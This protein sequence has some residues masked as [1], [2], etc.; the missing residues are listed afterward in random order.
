MLQRYIPGK[1][2]VSIGVQDKNPVSIGATGAVGP[3]GPPGP[4]TTIGATGAE[5][6]R[7]FMGIRGEKGLKGEAG[8]KGSTGAQGPSGPEGKTGP[9]GRQGPM[10]ATGVMGPHGYMGLRGEMGPSGPIGLRGDT[11]PMGPSG[12]RGPPGP[13]TTIGAT[14]A[15]GPITPA[16]V[17]FTDNDTTLSRTTITTDM[18]RTGQAAFIVSPS[19]GDT[20][21]AYIQASMS[22]KLSAITTTA[23]FKFMYCVGTSPIQ[24]LRTI[25]TCGS[26]QLIISGM[27]P[28]ISV[29]DAVYILF[30]TKVDDGTCEILEFTPVSGAIYHVS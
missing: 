29:G 13:A 2:M 1:G 24:H 30:N 5:G 21:N 20:T 14:G 16:G 22:V 8:P 3:Q 11:G 25:Y 15:Q 9:E 7:G 27:I 18:K 17:Y 19:W 4:A 26:D 12:P 28:N 10:G 6:P 23:T